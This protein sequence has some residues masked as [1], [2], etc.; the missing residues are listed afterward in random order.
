MR[1]V[2]ITGLGVVAP[3]GVGKKDFWDACVNGRSGIGPIRSFD[4]SGH[5]VKIAGEVSDFDVTPFIPAEHRRSLKIM[6]RAMRFAVGASGLAV[7]DSGLELKS[8]N[9][10]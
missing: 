10:E 3:Y 2:V 1:R 5:P 9:P 7:Q 8:E 4:P 6:S